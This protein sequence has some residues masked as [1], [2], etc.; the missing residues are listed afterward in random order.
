MTIFLYHFIVKR[1]QT[2]IIKKLFQKEYPALL[3][4]FK[5]ESSYFKKKKKKGNKRWH[6]VPPCNTIAKI[7]TECVRDYLEE[8]DSIASAAGTHAAVP[9]RTPN[10]GLSSKTH[11]SERMLKIWV[12]CRK[13]PEEWLSEKST[14][15]DAYCYLCP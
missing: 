7:F 15:T 12:R 1:S 14:F 6:I 2:A 13:E 3:C 5:P 4:V 10:T 11:H 8:G 9:M